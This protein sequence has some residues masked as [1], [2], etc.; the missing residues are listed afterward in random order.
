VYI[1][2]GINGS[3]PAFDIATIKYS[4]AGVQQ[5]AKTYNGAKD[6]AD[7][8]NAIGIDGLGNVYVA[9]ASTGLTSAYD[10]ITLKYT[11]AGARASTP[12]ITQSQPENQQPLSFSLSQNS[13]NPFNRSTKII[14]TIPKYGNRAVKLPVQLMIYNGMGTR[15][16]TPVNKELDAGTYQVEVNGADFTAGVYLYTLTEGTFRE[17]KKMILIKP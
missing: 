17:T 3:S 14:F 7:V 9:G 12:V 15:V 6:S 1:T 2:G 16:A 8:G 13:P 11:A 5:W 4:S 10:F